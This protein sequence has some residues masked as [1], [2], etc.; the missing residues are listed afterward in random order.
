MSES[1]AYRDFEV[2]SP[3]SQTDVSI[4]G[5]GAMGSAVAQAFL[6]AGRRVTVWNRTTSRTERL[7]AAGA[8]I[9]TSVTAAITAS[10]VTIVILG[11]VP[12][13]S[14]LSDDV[15]G[16]AKGR[17]LV[18]FTTSSESEICDVADRCR[19]AEVPF[20]AGGILGYPR[21]IARGEA[22]ILYSGDLAAFDRHGSLLRTLGGV[23]DCVGTNPTDAQATLFPVTLLAYSA[24]GGFL[25]GLAWAEAK[26]VSIATITAYVR[27]LALPLLDDCFAD[28][29]RRIP[30]RLYEPDQATIDVQIDAF[31]MMLSQLRDAHVGSATFQAFRDYSLAAQAAGLGGADISAVFEIL[32]ATEKANPAPA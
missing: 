3:D 25:E 14:V 27:S 22:A 13:G 9:A 4:V 20:L 28:L 11:Y 16:A 12:L 6:D 29:G 32:R 31:E 10:P 15:L 7:A 24:M 19:S 18:S 23:H 8:L 26:G 1:N 5:I 21:S 30:D 17:T 2:N